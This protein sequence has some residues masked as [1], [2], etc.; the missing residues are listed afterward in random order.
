M[1]QNPL[2]TSKRIYLDHS[3]TTPVDP[4]VLE[5]MLPFLQQQYGNP[6]SLHQFGREARTALGNA[7]AKIANSFNARE[8]EIFFTSGGTEADNFALQGIAF[9]NREKGNHI[10]TT[11]V[12][13]K[14]V[15]QTCKMLEKKGFEITYLK[16][17]HYGQ[18]DP[19]LVKDAIRPQT[20]LISIIH[21]NNETGTINPIGEIG[22]IA[23]EAGVYFHSDCVQSFGKTPLNVREMNVDLLSISAHKIY[24]PK[25]AGA[26]YIRRGTE[27][28]T[29]FFGGNHENKR[30]AGT[31]NLPGITGFAKATELMRENGNEIAQFV[32][33]LRNYFQKQLLKHIDNIQ[34]NGH[35]DNRLYNLLN[36]SFLGCDSEM[37]L[38]SLDMKGIA[39]SIGSACTSGSIELSHVLSAMGLSNAAVKSAIRFSLGKDN[40]REEIDDVLQALV[41]IVN[42]LRKR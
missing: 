26:L 41:E 28:D 24:G 33:E 36:V 14:A 39:V 25:G 18:V 13:H 2:S 17:D 30:R 29:I 9:H 37:L 22:K 8:S 10:I 7:R 20:I 38:L 6:S 11:R 32:G 27:I 19:Q 40:T 35:P 1:Q 3:A 4:Q 34:V 31:E 15:L 12:E 23:G 21:G 16:P 42:Q 5:A